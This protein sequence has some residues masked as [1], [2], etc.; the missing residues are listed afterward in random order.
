MHIGP[1]ERWDQLFY[2]TP[3]PSPQVERGG[4]KLFG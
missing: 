4:K 3:D 1:A 2:L